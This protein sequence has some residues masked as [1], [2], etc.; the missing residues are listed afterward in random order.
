M[1]LGVQ[2]RCLLVC[3]TALGC[4]WAGWLRPAPAR[5]SGSGSGS[6]EQQKLPGSVRGA[7]APAFVLA[8]GGADMFPPLNNNRGGAPCALCN[9]PARLPGWVWGA[10]GLRA[11]TGSG[12]GEGDELG[13]LGE[14]WRLSARYNE[15]FPLE[16][17]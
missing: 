3:F 6:D 9:A 2:A 11:V 8:G 14:L 16:V 5:R 17:S 4:A 13:K 12:A 15:I 1:A 10:D 7:S